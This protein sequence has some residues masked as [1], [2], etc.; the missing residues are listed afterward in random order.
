MCTSTEWKTGFMAGW[1]SMNPSTNI[2]T[3]KQ[4]YVCLVLGLT[5]VPSVMPILELSPMVNRTNADEWG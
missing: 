5:L 1:Q 3:N 4:A 2:Q